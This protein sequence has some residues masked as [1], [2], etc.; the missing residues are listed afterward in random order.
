MCRSNE[1]SLTRAAGALVRGVHLAAALRARLQ[2]CVALHAA[3]GAPLPRALLRLLS[4]ALCLIKVG[5]R[6]SLV[7][8]GPGM[9]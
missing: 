6:P 5:R 9:K 7:R 3:L 8:N 2:A 1:A 4:H